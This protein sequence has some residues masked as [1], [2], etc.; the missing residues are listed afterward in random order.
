MDRRDKKIAEEL[1][2]KIEDIMPVL[3][4]KVFGSRARGDNDK[5]SDL[6]VFVKVDILNNEIKKQIR[7]IAWEI[8]LEKSI[9]ISPL[10]FSRYEIEET[11]LRASPILENIEKE[12]LSL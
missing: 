9:Y 11:A 1:K 6:D 4:Y 7:E 12:G 10:I 5:Y 2:K 8:G 3:D